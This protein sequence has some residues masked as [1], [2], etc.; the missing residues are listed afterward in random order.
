MKALLLDKKTGVK[1]RIK[2]RLS[3]IFLLFLSASLQATTLNH[4]NVIST[5]PNQMM[6][7]L[8]FSNPI[9][10]PTGFVT[11]T[12]PRL[13]LDFMDVDKH[14]NAKTQSIQEGFLS[15]IQTI[16]A[17][18]RTRL[19][20]N[21]QQKIS[22]NLSPYQ[23][24]LR[25]ILTKIT[26]P[27]PKIAV[28]APLMSPSLKNTRPTYAKNNYSKHYVKAIDFKRNKSDGGEIIIDLSDENVVTNMSQEDNIIHL[29]LLDTHAPGPLQR[30]LDVMDFATPVNFINTVSQGNQ[31]DITIETQGKVDPTTYQVNKQLIVAVN[32]LS[33]E[34]TLEAEANP[35]YTGKPLSLN[36]QNIPIRSVLEVLAEFTKIN[37]IASDQVQGNITL[38][39][40][41]IP[42]DEAL[43]IIL[44]ANNLGKKQVGNVIMIAPTTELAAEE[45]ARLTAKEDLKALEPMQTVY[46]RLNYAKASDVETLIKSEN[47]S[48]LSS[49]GN[50]SVDNRTNTLILQ[51]IPSSINNI[52]ELIKKLDVPVQQVMI[53]ARI[54]NVDTS[55]ERDLGIRWGITKPEHVS[56]TLNGA[57]QMLQNYQTGSVANPV[58]AV[59]VGDRLNVDLGASI[60][61]VA[62][63]PSIG[64][65]LA[66]LGG[67]YMLDLELSAI[68][69]EGGGQ[70]ISSPKLVTANQHEALI[71]SG[72]EIP[73]QQQTSSGATAVEFKKAV[74]S[75]KVTPQIT[76]DGKIIMDIKVNQDR[77]DPN[78][79]V[80]NVPAIATQEVQ[81]NVLVNN[82]E[83][84]VLGGIYKEEKRN[85]VKRVPFL[86]S[87]P[88]LGAFFRNTYKLSTQT[89]LLIFIRPKIIQQLPVDQ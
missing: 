50:A 2:Q 49:R 5:N 40:N 13:I 7:D 88:F 42:W 4:I 24:H 20:L 55:F 70:L 33:K 41:N 83:T 48:L 66:K 47:S 51:D 28:T 36:F 52:E 34:A 86:G 71:E 76:P 63:A 1:D 23:N 79:E 78:L 9:K 58:S 29:Q 54:V 61:S 39:L 82:G 65:A 72:T 45:K 53:E 84:V 32:P 10:T 22:Y 46:M 60:D 26:P 80:D 44:K 75:L 56:G 19:V 14:L 8:Q 12:P 87:I 37:I 89:E 30:R 64:V 67:G 85:N 69:A 3:L 62:Q 11:T 68:E 73:Y 16:T 31:T 59:P 15:N 25:I 6:V 77:V 74:L 57:N 18:K 35:T 21:A 38:R 81:T 27:P 17:N 43:D